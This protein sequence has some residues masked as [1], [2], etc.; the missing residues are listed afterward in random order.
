MY[1]TFLLI[2]C[3]FSSEQAFVYMLT[4]FYLVCV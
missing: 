2:M 4:G 3:E 1:I